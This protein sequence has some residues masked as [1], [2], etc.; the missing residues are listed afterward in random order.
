MVVVIHSPSRHSPKVFPVT[1][2]SLGPFYTRSTIRRAAPR[3]IEILHQYSEPEG[4]YS[5]SRALSDIV[6]IIQ[7][8]VDTR[9]ALHRN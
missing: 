9:T 3:I 2:F 7:G 6:Q 8:Q 4:E 1:V 5:Q